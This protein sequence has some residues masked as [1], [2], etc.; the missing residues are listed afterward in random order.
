[1]F[2]TEIAQRC[3]NLIAQESVIWPLCHLSL[4]TFIVKRKNEK[5]L[6]FGPPEGWAAVGLVSPAFFNRGLWA[7]L[8][9]VLGS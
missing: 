3:K 2:V 7:H 6:K 8:L 5:F 1:M 4:A 9:R